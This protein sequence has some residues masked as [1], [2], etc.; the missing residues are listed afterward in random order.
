MAPKFSNG[1]LTDAGCGGGFDADEWLEATFGAHDGAGV[2]VPAALVSAGSGGHPYP[3][4][5]VTLQPGQSVHMNVAITPPT[6]SGTYAFSFSAASSGVKSAF[7][8]FGHPIMLTSQV[9][10][11]SGLP[12]TTPAMK[13]QIPANSQDAWICP[14]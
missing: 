7:I 13:A 11:W 2:T 5:P 8:P 10:K 4:L 14:E 9:R 6:I 12:C 3:P 1:Q